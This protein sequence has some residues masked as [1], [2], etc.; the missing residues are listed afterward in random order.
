MRAFWKIREH[1]WIAN[2]QLAEFEKSEQ[3][4]FIRFDVLRRE[5]PPGEVKGTR[6]DC[7]FVIDTIRFV[8]LF[9]AGSS[10]SVACRRSLIRLFQSMLP[11]I[12]PIRSF[13]RHGENQEEFPR[14]S[15]EIVRV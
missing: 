8:E 4:Y 11:R 2:F 13:P 5:T 15:V 1:L 12:D 10:F 6:H 3:S 7:R 14:E 9:R